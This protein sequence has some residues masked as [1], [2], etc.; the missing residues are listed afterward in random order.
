MASSPLDDS[1]EGSG[2]DDH[3]ARVETLDGLPRSIAEEAAGDVS[4][5]ERVPRDTSSTYTTM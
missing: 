3:R 1:V 4:R 2:R 5:P